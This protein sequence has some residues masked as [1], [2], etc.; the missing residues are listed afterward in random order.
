MDGS[1]NIMPKT[2]WN[3]QINLT[4]KLTETEM[5][6]LRNDFELHKLL[7]KHNKGKVPE[8]NFLLKGMLEGGNNVNN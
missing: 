7:V 1:F 6:A 5:H 2:V 8:Y 3:I 4:E